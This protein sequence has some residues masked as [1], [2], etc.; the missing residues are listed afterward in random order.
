MDLNKWRHAVGV[1]DQGSFTA[2]AMRLHISQPALSRSIQSLERELGLILF[3]RG[4]AGIAITAVGQPILEQAR[5]L[6]GQAEALQESVRDI[7]RG[8]AGAVRFGVGPMFA[9]LLDQ[10]LPALWQPKQSV[11]VQ[12]HVLPVERLVVRLLRGELD[13]FI[14]DG[15]AARGQKAI[16]VEPLGEAPVGYFVRPSHPLAARSNLKISELASFPRVAPNLPEATIEQDRD[17]RMSSQVSAGQLN[18]ERLD[19]LVRMASGSDA[20][21]L[22]IAPM[23]EDTLASGELVRLDISDLRHWRADIVLARSALLQFSPLVRRYAEA[24][25]T[26]VTNRI[27]TAA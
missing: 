24:F 26:A 8:D 12:A 10:V 4:P 15:R 18:C 19:L 2:A 11:T 3:E 25:G 22:A 14:A 1:A 16:A 13:F 5:A 27:A 7:V 20:V 17:I 9:T 23:I 6:L 21:L